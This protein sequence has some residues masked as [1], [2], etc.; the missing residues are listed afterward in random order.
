MFQVSPA[1]GVLTV[2]P[3]RAIPNHVQRNIFARRR[4]NIRDNAPVPVSNARIEVNA[5]SHDLEQ[6]SLRLAPVRLSQFW[7]IVPGASN[8]NF[9]PVNPD[10]QCIPVMNGQHCIA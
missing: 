10:L 8:R 1:P 9:L 4:P 2:P 3:A 5:A 7:R 6:F